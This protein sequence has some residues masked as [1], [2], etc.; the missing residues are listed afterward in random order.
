MKMEGLNRT[1]TTGESKPYIKEWTKTG[2]SF[3]INA[4]RSN[5]S[6]IQHSNTSYSFYKMSAIASV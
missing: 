1:I 2:V 5:D 6:H 3:G 4:N